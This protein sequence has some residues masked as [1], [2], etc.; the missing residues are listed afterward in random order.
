VSDGLPRPLVTATIGGAI[1]NRVQS[2]RKPRPV[3]PAKPS[4]VR[5][6]KGRPRKA[7]PM[8]KAQPFRGRGGRRAIERTVQVCISVLESER[9]AIDASCRAVQMERSAWLRKAAEHF[10]AFLGAEG[11]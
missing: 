9:A 11:M 5:R 4:R 1:T 6:P 8:R 7:R 2:I 10:L 3:K